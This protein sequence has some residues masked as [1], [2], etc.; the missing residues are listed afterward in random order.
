MKIIIPQNIFAGIFAFVVSKELHANIEV[1]PASMITSELESG[2]YDLALIPSLDLLKHNDLFVSSKTAISF[3]GPISNSYL[4][5]I[6]EQANVESVLLRGDV[7]INE[8]V[9]SK[10]LFSESYKINPEIKLDSG[11]ID[12][13]NNN[14]LIS[15]NENLE[16]LIKRNGVSFSESLAEIINYPYSNFI[17][18]AKDQNKITE[19]NSL[20]SN[21]DENIDDKLD[22]IVSQLSLKSEI[23]SFLK[24]NIN[25]VYY[26]MTEN[27]ITG[28][29]ETMR[30]V[31]YHGI[32]EEIKE[33]RFV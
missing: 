33:I 16:H 27:E 30:L 23:V 13:E 12:F 7:S 8:I 18:A 26:E 3:D 31:F 19:F 24:N 4:Y 25:S 20:I 5:F 6:P 29:H 2:S 14:Y 22:T 32:G 11:E 21:I 17:F 9:L 10:I 28:L 1:K 15:G